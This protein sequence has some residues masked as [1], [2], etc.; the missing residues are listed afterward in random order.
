MS[1]EIPTPVTD[2]PG[3]RTIRFYVE[4]TGQEFI[5]GRFNKNSLEKEK[6][7]I[8]KE[9]KEKSPEEKLKKS[10]QSKL[11]KLFKAQERGANVNE[12]IEETKAKL[13]VIFVPERDDEAL[14]ARLA[15]IEEELGTP[16]EFPTGDDFEMRSADVLDYSMQL[17]PF[18]GGLNLI[19]GGLDVMLSV[20]VP[21][22]PAQKK[23]EFDVVLV[24]PVDGRV[25]FIV[26]CKIKGRMI[27]A[28]I[29]KF[30]AALAY[31]KEE[32][33]VT[34]VPKTIVT[35]GST[36]QDGKE[37]QLN[38][39]DARM[40]YMIDEDAESIFRSST[41]LSM[42][43]DKL[44]KNIPKESR[45]DDDGNV[46]EFPVDLDSLTQEERNDLYTRTTEEVEDIFVTKGMSYDDRIK[47]ITSLLD[48]FSIVEL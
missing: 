43:T 1:I 37:I 14:K 9:L 29:P 20:N 28:D 12:V 2:V 31:V 35:E 23:G 47:K 8:M 10:L 27:L 19:S 11:D 6:K 44:A 25:L 41:V 5:N 46:R 45:I 33:V 24:D 15:E 7:E 13:E 32:G 30:D 16:S 18:A 48:T 34:V 39:Q 40:V 21:G 4:T 22:M 17:L 26:E 42:V 38:F 36:F 3:A